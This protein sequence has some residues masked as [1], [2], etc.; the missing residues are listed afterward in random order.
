MPLNP[1]VPLLHQIDRS[2]IRPGMNLEVCQCAEKSLIMRTPVLE[3]DASPQASFDLQAK[4]STLAHLL[5][6]QEP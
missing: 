1:V 2:R 5:E 6:T 3:A 4:A